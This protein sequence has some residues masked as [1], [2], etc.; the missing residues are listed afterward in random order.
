[1]CFGEGG[2]GFPL[3]A[4]RCVCVEGGTHSA[5]AG[6]GGGSRNTADTHVGSCKGVSTLQLSMSLTH[7]QLF[8]SPLFFGRSVS[9]P[10]SHTPPFI[11]TPLC[12]PAAVLCTQCCL[13]LILLLLLLLLLL[14]NSCC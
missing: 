12:L 14:R 13:Y 11:P 7:K 10:S 9:F 6:E 2:R 4:R 5:P 3:S 8:F 1:V